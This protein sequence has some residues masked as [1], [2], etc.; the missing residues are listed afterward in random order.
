MTA[1][2]ERSEGDPFDHHP[3]EADD[4]RRQQQCDPEPH[5]SAE[6]GG[7]GEGQIRPERE[8]LAVAEVE[9]VH[10]P[11]NERQSRGD[12]DVNHPDHQAVQEHLEQ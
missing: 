4:D 3:H 7:D 12:Q 9:D 8:Q 2:V 1:A 6:R 11:E 5:A 10:H